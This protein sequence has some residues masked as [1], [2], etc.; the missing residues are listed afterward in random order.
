MKRACPCV[1]RAMATEADAAKTELIHEL[2]RKYRYDPWR[3]R[4][5]DMQRAA[6]HLENPPPEL[7]PADLRARFFTATTVWQANGFAFTSSEASSVG[8]IATPY[9]AV[10]STCHGGRSRIA[11]TYDDQ[12][13]ADFDELHL[14]E[15]MGRPSVFYFAFKDA[16]GGP[17]HTYL[18][19]NPYENCA[20]R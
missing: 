4:I 9:R 19:L 8:Q 5:F 16:A 2:A 11:L 13:I 7:L 6:V 3:I 18:I 1:M 10:A 17:L 20:Y 12:P 15:L 14:V